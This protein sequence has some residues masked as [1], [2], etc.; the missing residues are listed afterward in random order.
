MK[1]NKCFIIAEI[2]VNHNGSLK[3]AKKLIDSAITCNID[4]VKFQTFHTKLL[5][6]S[7]APKAEYQKNNNEESQADM[8][9]ELELTDENFKELK[10]YCDEKKIEFI[11]TPFDIPSVELLNNLNVNIFK[12]GSGDI[13]NF[14]LLK[15]VALT[16]KPIILSTGLSTNIEIE[17][18]L[19]YLRKYNSNIMLLHCLSSYPAKI[20]D[21]NL[22]CITSMKNKFNIPIGFSDHTQSVDI[23]GL[24]VM[25]GASVI[26]K[27]F[28]L[29]N[30][31]SGPDH[32]ASMNPENMK[33]Y[34]NKIR[35]AELI[36]G[37]GVK[38]C[39]NSEEN[40][41][42]VARRSLAV[43]KD[44][45]ENHI[46]T[47]EDIISLRPNTGIPSDKIEDIIGKKLN[48]NLSKNTLLQYKFLERNCVA[49]MIC[50]VGTGYMAV[51]YTKALINLNRMF[52]VIG[53]TEKGCEKFREQFNNIR[54]LS[55]GLE[56]VDK[57][58]LKSCYSIIIA[59]PINLLEKHLSISVECNIK[60]ILVEK[61]AGLDLGK[62]KEISN[63]AKEKS[64][65]IVVG[66]NRRFY[67]SVIKA[68]EMIGK[69]GGVKYFR[70]DFSE[71]VNRIDFTKF[72][73]DVLN[74]WI[75][76]MSS[77]VIDT[78]FYLVGGIPETMSCFHNGTIEWHRNSM[79]I[80]DGMTT[81]GVPFNYCS[82]FIGLGR[83]GLELT[84]NNHIIIFKPFEILQVINRH[85]MN[86][87]IIT[88]DTSNEIEIKN[89]ILLQTKC[90][91]EN[92]TS[93]D[94]LKLEEQCFNIENIYN[95]IAGY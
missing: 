50:L 29:D 58:L 64:I 60:N 22:S 5:V 25:L 82:N 72:K 77:H 47:E 18:T 35:E 12:I 62:L 43:N 40:T 83:W 39:K 24:A 2:G 33:I 53:N 69:D 49:G 85:Q 89:G 41:K 8:L 95:K 87:E 10:L 1:S 70:F 57:K 90:F 4:A 80:G 42:L 3:Q 11:S 30:N 94:L 34:V 16:G 78:A 55:G 52:F 38:Q 48:T 26:E 21:V 75:I 71:L 6:T 32:K 86:P 20:E 13:T 67:A 74:K 81:N 79:F 54:V 88:L 19:N 15:K 65:N 61:P 45:L 51:E 63:L 56:N 68:K 36:L 28:T 66:Y 14:Q 17:K 91:L 92:S 37:T 44:L 73:E 84:T 46:L 31:L 27:H 59:S 7:D 76:S 9:Q 93:K 23:G